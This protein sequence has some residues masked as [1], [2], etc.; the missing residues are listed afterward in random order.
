MVREQHLRCK[1]KRWENNKRQEKKS[2]MQRLRV[3]GCN[4]EAAAL[5]LAMKEN[6]KTLIVHFHWLWMKSV[7][8]MSRCPL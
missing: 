7:A 1:N 3:G 8:A 2:K 5:T 6:P 4:R